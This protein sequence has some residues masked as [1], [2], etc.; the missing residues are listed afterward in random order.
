MGSHGLCLELG[1]DVKVFSAFIW[2][3]EIVEWLELHPVLFNL[4]LDHR[5]RQHL[6]ASLHGLLSLFVAPAW[7]GRQTEARVA[8][9]ASP[10]WPCYDS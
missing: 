2:N 1:V 7:G 8:K 6:R 9:E 10:R 3:H 5:A 4:G